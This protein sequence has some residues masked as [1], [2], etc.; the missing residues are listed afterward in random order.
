LDEFQQATLA[1]LPAIQFTKKKG[2]RKAS[3]FGNA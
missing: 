1:P 3:L 2:Q